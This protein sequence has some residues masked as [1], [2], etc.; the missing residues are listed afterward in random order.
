VVFRRAR[1]INSDL[2][3]TIL[4]LVDLRETTLRQVLLPEDVDPNILPAN[5]VPITVAEFSLALENRTEIYS[6]PPA[7][8]LSLL[9]QL[10]APLVD[11]MDQEEDR[12]EPETDLGEP[13]S[14][15]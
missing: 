10:L 3:D 7:E 2:R 9:E 15:Q 4:E 1:I 5:F 6:E 11:D 14:E 13:E 12:E 8:G